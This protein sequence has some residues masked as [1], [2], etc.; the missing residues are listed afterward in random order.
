M[1]LTTSLKIHLLGLILVI[2]IEKSTR[3]FV[4]SEKLKGSSCFFGGIL[5]VLLGWPI[6]GMVIEIYGFVALFG[7][8]FPMA[9]NTLRCLP[10]TGTIL[11]LPGI[12]NVCDSI[13]GQGQSWWTFENPSQPMRSLCFRTRVSDTQVFYLFNKILKLLHNWICYVLNEYT[14]SSKKLL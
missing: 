5:V 4:Q 14:I 11:A 7:G 1:T 6:V 12:S 13:V 10:V 2:G 8:F 3:F 9:I